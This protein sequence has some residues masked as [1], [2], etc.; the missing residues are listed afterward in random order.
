MME[1]HFMKM[2]PPKHEKHHL[3]KKKNSDWFIIAP[4]NDYEY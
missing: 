1:L 2:E 3:K 4:W